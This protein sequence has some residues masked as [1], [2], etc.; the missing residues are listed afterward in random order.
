MKRL[1]ALILALL[2]AG[3]SGVDLG[4]GL[5][6]SKAGEILGNDLDKT[7]DLAQRYG[8]PEV[9]QCATFLQTALTSED[10]DLAKLK[11][12]LAEDT[13]GLLS[14]ALKAALVAELARGLN[15]PAKQ[16][17]FQQDFDVACKAV[18]GTIVLNLARDAVKSKTGGLVG[19]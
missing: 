15:D 9:V 19:R 16:A 2:I 5:L 14:A 4:N 3:C 12:L 18:A 7:I 10:A 1:S 11:A 6:G 8:K 17:K 13:S